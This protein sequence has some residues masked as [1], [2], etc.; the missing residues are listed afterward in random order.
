VLERFLCC[1]PAG[2]LVVAL[3]I[4]SAFVSLCLCLWA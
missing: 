4:W 3:R 1:L 2:G